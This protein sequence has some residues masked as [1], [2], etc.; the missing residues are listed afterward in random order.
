[1]KVPKRFGKYKIL[2]EIG[3]GSMGLVLMA[4]QDFL[5]RKVAIK[6]LPKEL[7]KSHPLLVKRFRNEAIV[8]AKIIHPYLVPIFDV[9]YEAGF[10]YIVMEYIAGKTLDDACR[11]YKWTYLEQIDIYIKITKALTAIHSVEVVHRDLKAT[12]IIYSNEGLVKILDFG[13]AKA[14]NDSESLTKEGSIMGSPDFMSPEQAR[15]EE[16]DQRSDIFSFGVIMFLLLTGVNP[17]H[18]TKMEIREI[19]QQR[20]KLNQPPSMKEIKSDIPSSLDRIVMKCLTGKREQRFQTAEELLE[21]LERCKRGLQRKVANPTL[22]LSGIYKPIQK[23]SSWNLPIFFNAVLVGLMFSIKMIQI[24]YAKPPDLTEAVKHLEMEE[25]FQEALFQIRHHHQN[26]PQPQIW[27]QKNDQLEEK[28]F[29]VATSDYI[30]QLLR[31][32]KKEEA[33]ELFQL[34]TKLFPENNE[35]LLLSTYFK[36]SEFKD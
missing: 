5:N 28:L 4:E 27:K 24:N 29:I 31:F 20:Q 22:K 11:E 33:L 30:K 18:R 17:F 7:E 3:A 1:M 9:G 13:I 8:A 14:S 19:V 21:Q 36:K 10:H 23:N 2:S 35:I 26:S 25:K 12:N 16:V 32:G 34:L 15:G 6:I